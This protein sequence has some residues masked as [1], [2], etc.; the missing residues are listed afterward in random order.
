MFK[1]FTV[2][3]ISYVGFFLFFRQLNILH[4]KI[5]ETRKFVK[6]YRDIGWTPKLDC[7]PRM[8]DML[9]RFVLR[10]K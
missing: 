4:T 3:A 5:V 7:S 2:Y 6:A 10:T 9:E 1:N 8:Q